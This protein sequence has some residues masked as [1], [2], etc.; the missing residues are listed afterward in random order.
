MG[1]DGN[2][3]IAAADV[4]VTVRFINKNAQDPQFVCIFVEI[5]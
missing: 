5:E 4:D 1:F 2:L 3:A